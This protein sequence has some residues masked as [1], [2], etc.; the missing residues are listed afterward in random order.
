MEL[1]INTLISDLARMAAAFLLAF[2]I[3][4]ERGHRANRIGFR[5]LPLVAMAACGFSLI[6][7]SGDTDTVE[8]RTR[9][10]QGVITG[11]GFIGGGAIVK[12]E[13][14]V[15]GVATAASIWTAGAIG[16]AV[17]YDKINIAVV[18]CLASVISLLVLGRIRP[19]DDGDDAG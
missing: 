3:G 9:V 18:L 16:L 19:E 1:D 4:W 8:H 10:M 7:A 13:Q 14:N 17:G 2:P 6:I 15:Q 5:T 12:N 11:I